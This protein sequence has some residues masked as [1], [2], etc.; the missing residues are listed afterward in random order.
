MSFIEKDDNNNI[1]SINVSNSVIIYT[2]YIIIVRSHTQNTPR[3]VTDRDLIRKLLNFNRLET[4]EFAEAR[5]GEE[6][7]ARL[8]LLALRGGAN[9]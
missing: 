2:K 3:R 5:F 1:R 9:F 8:V 4:N 7:P 6:L